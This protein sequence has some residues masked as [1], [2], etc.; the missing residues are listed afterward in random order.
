MAALSA[1]I[2]VL[3]MVGVAGVAANVQLTTIPLT[4]LATVTGVATPFILNK[5]VFVSM[6]VSWLT[7]VAE[8]ASDAGLIR[9]VEFA[10]GDTDEIDGLRTPGSAT[11][12]RTR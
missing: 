7:T 11:G 4:L 9:D 10:G 6:V 8:V 3:V 12:T 1:K 5:T 2:S